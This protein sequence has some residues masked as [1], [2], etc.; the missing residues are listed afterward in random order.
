MRTQKI[1][2]WISLT[3]IWSVSAAETLRVA[4]Y[5]LENYLEM[6]RTVAE[7]WRPDYLSQKRKNRLFAR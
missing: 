1:I 5:N 7:V 6:D 2:V 3:L 4:T